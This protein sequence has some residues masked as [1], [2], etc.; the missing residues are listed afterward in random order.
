M[1]SR[2]VTY[3]GLKKLALE[4]LSFDIEDVKE[5]YLE[6]LQIH[7]DSLTHL[8]LARNKISNIFMQ[9]ICDT[10]RTSLPNLQ[11]IDLRHLKETDKINWPKMLS[12]IAMLASKER[13]KPIKVIISDYQTQK[14]R[15]DIFN[16]LQDNQPNI[17]LQ[18][19]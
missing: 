14:K 16:Y 18:Y 3:K 12:S 11:C 5:R 1:S 19:E 4:L 9:I 10:L 6:I 2:L 13:A 17:E 15:S 8:S 7:S